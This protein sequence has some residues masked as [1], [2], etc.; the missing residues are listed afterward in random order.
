MLNADYEPTGPEEEI[1]SALEA[2]GRMQSKELQAQ[3]EIERSTLSG[4]LHRLAAAGW[5][6]K[7]PDSHGMYEFHVDPREASDEELTDRCLEP[8]IDRVGRDTVIR[9]AGRLGP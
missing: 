5:I 4:H 1:L 8:L 9:Q 3:L 6:V 2:K 7:P